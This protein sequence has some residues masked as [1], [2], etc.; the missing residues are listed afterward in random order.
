MP[1]TVNDDSRIGGECPMRTNPAALV[2]PTQD[3]I[4]VI[5]ANRVLTGSRL[6]G[7][8]AKD[9]IVTLE[10]G[11]HQ[12]RPSLCLAEVRE[13]EVEDYNITSYKLA[14]AASSSGVSQS[15][16]S[17][18]SAASAGTALSMRASLSCRR[19]ASKWSRSCSGM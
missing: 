11:D 18:D 15:L 8:L 16:A 1:G 3:K 14:Q 13:R 5:Q 17:D 12:C 4:N 9:D 19:K 7:D 10:R 6:A 2:E